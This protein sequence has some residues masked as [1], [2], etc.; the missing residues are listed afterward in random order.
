MEY[1]YLTTY[2]TKPKNKKGNEVVEYCKKFDNIIAEGNIAIDAIKTELN[3]I[4]DVLNKKHKRS[5]EIYT[6]FYAHDRFLI[7]K[8]NENFMNDL[9]RISV[10]KV[11]GFYRFSES[12]LTMEIEN[13]NE[14]CE[15]N[16]V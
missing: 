12:V 8:E 4:C 9:F 5:R 16:E 3:A 10:V 2:Y 15:Q 1:Y 7:I 13:Q 6:S 14:L 11:R